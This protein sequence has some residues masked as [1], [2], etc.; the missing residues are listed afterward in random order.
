MGGLAR[1]LV[2]FRGHLLKRLCALGHDVIACAGDNDPAVRTQLQ[3]WGVRF[4]AVP[5]SR[6]GRNPIQELAVVRNLTHVLAEERPDVYLGYT[7]KPVIYGGWAAA[8]AGVPRRVA[9]VTGLGSAFLPSD[10]KGRALRCVVVELYRSAL[11]RYQRVVFQNPDDCNEFVSRRLVSTEQLARVNGSGIDLREFPVAALPDD[12]PRFLL[13]ARL[14]REK[15]IAE[16]AEAARRVKQAYPEAVC[17]LLGPPY[18]SPCAI[19]VSQIREWERTCGL[20]YIGETDDVRPAIAASNV[21]VLPSY[22]EGVPRSTQEAMGMGRPIITT[23]VP[24]CRET[25][26]AER[27]GLL[28]PS[29]DSGQLAD[30]MMRLASDPLLRA[31]MGRESRRLAEER[32]DVHQVNQELVDLLVPESPLSRAA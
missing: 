9:L 6:T 23:D 29:Q 28:V 22:R 14:L 7:V 15:G 10:W 17:Q 2:N 21:Y 27:N 11:S 31:T 26:I 5:L 16:Y 18:D 20:E 30:A 3:A 13:I 32:F 12:R 25:V 1:S 24:G 19:P 4:R 8:S